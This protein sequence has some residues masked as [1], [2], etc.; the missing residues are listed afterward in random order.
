MRETR[1]DTNLAVALALALHALLALL[2]VF[3]MWWTHP[4]EQS[5]AGQPV[6]AD[7]FDPNFFTLRCPARVTE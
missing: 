6:D 5:V 4:A 3:G 7:I 1:A 2:L